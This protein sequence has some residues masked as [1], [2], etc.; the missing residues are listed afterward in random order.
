MAAGNATVAGYAWAGAIVGLVG[1]GLMTF[2]WPRTAVMV[3]TTV[4]GSLM[5]VCGACGVLVGQNL[6]PSLAGELTANDYLLGILIGVPA[7][8]GFTYQFATE[9][10]KVHKKRQATEKPPV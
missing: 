2:V 5:V 1:V 7:I 3:L 6:A 10:S 9:S 8:A 4:Q